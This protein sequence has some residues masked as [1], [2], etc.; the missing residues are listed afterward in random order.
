MNSPDSNPAVETIAR[1]AEETRF[2]RALAAVALVAVLGSIMTILDS[3][4]VNVATDTLSR[5]FR[6]PL[7]TVQWATSGYLLALAMVIPIT[8]WASDRFGSKRV[9][10]FSTCLFVVGSVL[11]GAAWSVVSLIVFRVL[12]GLGGG[13][14]LPV[15]MTMLTHAAGPKRLARAMSLAGGPLLL[16]PIIGAVLGGSLLTAFSWRWIFFIN[17]PV[18]VLT[19]VLAER[20]IKVDDRSPQAGRL[21]VTGLALLAPGIAA[22]ALGL[23]ASVSVGGFAAPVALF[24]VLAGAALVAL[25]VVHSLRTPQPLI[26]VRLF[27]RGNVAAAGLTQFFFA[28]AFF[29][30]MLLI[31]LYLQVVRG[32]SALGA[33]L[34]LI[35]YGVGAAIMMSMAGAIADKSGARRIVFAGLFLLAVGILGLTQL[36]AVTSYWL[37]GAAEVLLGLGMGATMLPGM[38][39]A[40]QAV[41]PSEVAR[42]TAAINVVVRL[43]SACGIALLALVLTRL[44]PGE[45]HGGLGGL[46]HPPAA[47]RETIALAFGHTFWWAEA[48]ILAAAVAAMRLPLRRSA[49]GAES[50]P[51]HVS[52]G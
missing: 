45:I 22:L 8:G 52:A 16:G 14:I 28:T 11:S 9:Y 46:S 19:I 26:D 15:A 17:V 4:I 25:F 48:L 3:T 29:G 27:Q 40:Y 37:L 6:A 12:Q 5:A 36:G 34:L 20:V 50:E 1:A 21:D 32:E 23:G 31:P 38:S 18:G 2:D 35:P 42:V 24:P 43:G 7:T 49:V 39:A 47:A 41:S 10:Q 44:L 30:S 13:M 51:D 33:G